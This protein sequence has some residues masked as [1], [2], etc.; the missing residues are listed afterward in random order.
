MTN[1]E[2]ILSELRKINGRLNGIDG[3]L[4]EIDQKLDGLKESHDDTRAGVNR[5]LEWADEC[6]YIVQF[7]LPKV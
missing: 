1:E 5:L 7:P 3:R 4:N 6:G 2:L